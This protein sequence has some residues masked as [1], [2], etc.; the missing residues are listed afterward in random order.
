[1]LSLLNKPWVSGPLALGAVIYVL[2]RFIPADWDKQLGMGE[3]V[4]GRAVEKV[5]SKLIPNLRLFQ[6]VPSKLHDEWKQPLRNN[7]LGRKLFDEIEPEM[8]LELWETYDLPQGT[9][10]QGVVLEE[11]RRA[12][13]ISGRTYLEGE[14]YGNFRVAKI[15]R[16][17]V[18]LTHSGGGREVLRVGGVPGDFSRPN[19][20][21]E[22]EKS[23]RTRSP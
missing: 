12:A 18:L 19:G 2:Y 1:M 10:L 13:V 8:E 3:A 7:Q 20:D 23:R 14:A 17:W 11:G 4:L 16:D 21:G 9:L 22:K 6:A 5:E 15:H